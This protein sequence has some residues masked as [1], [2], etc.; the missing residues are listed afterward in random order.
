MMHAENVSVAAAFDLSYE[1]LTAHQKRLFRR[2]GLHAG[3]TIDAYATAA[4]C[5]EDLSA[6][7]RN[8]E[9]LYDH[10]LLT[11]PS[12]GRYGMHDL[13]REFARA[14]AGSDDPTDCDAAAARLLDYY[15]HCAIIA[16][17]HFPRRDVELP[18]AVGDIPVFLPELSTHSQAVTWLE[19][20][21]ANLHAAVHD[22]IVRHREVNAII[23]PVAISQFLRTRG[24]WEQALG[25]HQA[26]EL[27]ARQAGDT[28]AQADALANL[29]LVQR[30][31]GNYDAATATLTQA[32]ELYRHT[33]TRSSTA[34]VLLCLG[35]V[36]RLTVDYPTAAATLNEALDLYRASEDRLGQAESLN[37]LGVVHRLSGNL[38]GALESHNHALELTRAI[39]DRLGEADTLRYLGGVQQETGE[40]TTVLANYGRALELY[41]EIGDQLGEAHALG[42]LGDVQ[43]LMGAS[44]TASS[45]LTQALTLYESLG[46]RLG[47]AEVL[48]HLGDLLASSDTVQSRDHHQKALTIARGISA[49]LEEAHA[50]EGTANSDIAEGRPQDA[51]MNLQQA[52]EIYQRIGSSRTERTAQKLS[53]INP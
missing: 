16:G 11:E 40:Y 23:I 37:E 27:A 41:K 51:A 12:R 19:T 18:Q 34:S 32:L 31:A 43:R 26:A 6:A 15:A 38:P 10:H 45:T 53:R 21:R 30:L 20:E 49:S 4:L 42:Y 29:G 44:A 14:L 9:D 48:N 13:I 46:H 1:D 5:A 2:L 50:L 47:Q 24:Q 25:F 17:R 39:G 36:Q 8:L 3:P 35:V 52:L 7:R 22:A 33:G 28:R